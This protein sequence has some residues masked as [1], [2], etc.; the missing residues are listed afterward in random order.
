MP[1]NDDADDD[2]DH[3]DDEPLYSTTPTYLFV[4]RKNPKTGRFETS[5]INIFAHSMGADFLWATGGKG[6][7]G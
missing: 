7:I 6:L 3:D 5:Q 4:V 2:G 1:N